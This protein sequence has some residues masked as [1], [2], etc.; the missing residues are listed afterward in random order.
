VPPPLFAAYRAF[1]RACERAVC[2]LKGLFALLHRLKR[3]ALLLHDG[4]QHDA[5][6]DL[7]EAAERNRDPMNLFLCC[8]PAGWGVCCQIR[9]TPVACAVLRS[10]SM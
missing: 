8:V 1:Q 6:V 9:A 5:E 3:A 2:R 7:I 10:E 4:V